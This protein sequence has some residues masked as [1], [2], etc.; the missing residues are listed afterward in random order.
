MPDVGDIR[1]ANLTV[2]PFDGTTSATL[3]VTDPDGTVTTPTPTT[4]D[5]G[6]TWTANVT[7]TQAG[8]WLLK[9]TVTGAGAGVEYQQ[10]YVSG[11][12]VAPPVS[13][14]VVSLERFKNWLRQ[15]VVNANPRDEELL[16]AL[17]SATEWVKWRLSGPLTVETFTERIYAHGSYLK[18]R[19]HPLVSV[20]SV[21]PQD[22][23]VLN[24]SAYIVDTTNSMIQM[25][26]QAYG[27]HDVVY[28]AGLTVITPRIELAGMEVGKHL[29]RALN[30]TAGR[31]RGAEELV[32]TPLG[33]AV[34]TRAEEMVA[35][36]P[37]Q[38]LMPGF[39]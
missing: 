15:S 19:K 13:T 35:A 16:L 3:Q 17:S 34:P 32:P 23:G 1:T 30:G 39:A 18:Q 21:T 14:L 33:F 36:D 27:F 12:P 22:A 9:W 25:L 24:A 20:V 26:Y 4:A 6:N 28:T 31:G 5:G 8:W 10:V 7:Y 11:A 29:W 38:H 37:D 2:A